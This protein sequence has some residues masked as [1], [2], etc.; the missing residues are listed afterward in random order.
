M[1]WSMKLRGWHSAIYSNLSVLELKENTNSAFFVRY[2]PRN[3]VCDYRWKSHGL[4][5]VSQLHFFSLPASFLSLQSTNSRAAT[6]RLL[7][8]SSPQS[9]SSLK[10]LS[11]MDKSPQETARLVFKTSFF[12]LKYF[13]FSFHLWHINKY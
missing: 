13:L 6:I 2:P 9:H 3:S 11:F 5:T 1:S 12:H 4:L 7:R 10:F 8:N